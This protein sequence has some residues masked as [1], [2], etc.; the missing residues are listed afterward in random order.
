MAAAVIIGLHR[1]PAPRHNTTQHTA[2][3]YDLVV[4]KNNIDNRIFPGAMASKKLQI[5][6]FLGISKHE[7]CNNQNKLKREVA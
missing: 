3:V 5:L 6:K 7:E 4:E 1:G 2:L